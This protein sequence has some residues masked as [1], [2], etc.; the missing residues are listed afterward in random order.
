MTT[1]K[2]ISISKTTILDA[3][4][5]KLMG[6]NHSRENPADFSNCDITS[7]D[8]FIG[9]DLTGADFSEADCFDLSL[10][11]CTL[12]GCNFSGTQYLERVDFSSTI[13]DRAT[14]DTIQAGGGHL[15]QSVK[16]IDG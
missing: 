15:P 13:M 5:I 2:I 8:Y 7:N 12:T 9:L 14:A 1:K 16:I 6:E 3:E 4:E 11:G 10:E